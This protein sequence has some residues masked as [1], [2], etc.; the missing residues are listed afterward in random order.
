MFLQF[1]GFQQALVLGWVIGAELFHGLQ[2]GKHH[3]VWRRQ[4][5]RPEVVV[6][7]MHCEQEYRSEER[8]LTVDHG[9]DIEYPARQEFRG[10]GRESQHQAA[11]T[12]DGHAPEHGPIVELLEVCPALEQRF[13]TLAEEP[14]E[15]AHAVGQ[16]FPVGDQRI[17][18][19]PAEG[20]AAQQFLHH[21]D[22]VDEEYPDEQYGGHPMDQAQAAHSAQGLGDCRSPGG[23]GEQHCGAGQ[24]QGHGNQCE[25]Q[26][27]DAPAY[28]EALEV[29]L[30][31]QLES[32][33]VN[34]RNGLVM[35]AFLPFAVQPQGGMQPE[36]QEHADQQR[37]HE[38]GDDPHLRVFGE[39]V[40]VGVRGEGG[41]TGGRQR[42]FFAVMATLTGLQAVR[43]MHFRIRILG[44]QNVVAAVAVVAFCGIGRA[45]FRGLAVIRV[46]VRQQPVLV[47]I[48]AFLDI[49]QLERGQR[50]AGDLVGGV[51]IGADRRLDV[52][53]GE[54]LLAMHRFGVGIQLVGVAFL[55]AQRGYAKSPGRVFRALLVG[56]HV[57]AV[58][59]MALS[60]CGLGLGRMVRIRTG[61]ERFFV[62]RDVLGH[63]FQTRFGGT[64]P[65]LLRLVG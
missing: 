63:D 1:S 59:V 53:F 8:F 29:F 21:I 2:A 5:F 22:K 12:D 9:R 64:G 32:G 6:E 50:G 62:G 37:E 47:A 54:H 24:Y 57:E 3:D 52:L 49:E 46:A 17:G 44:R 36:E 30:L 20:F 11:E 13:F 42:P 55:A 43:G 35:L 40:A 27:S 34:D 45:Q 25:G 48:A 26:V 16:V 39:V 65:I 7:E 38:L 10:Y 33:G 61:M 56:R 19:E 31:V 23:I 18:A 15:H 58:G 4:F 51:A 60:A 14:L 41:E 28:R